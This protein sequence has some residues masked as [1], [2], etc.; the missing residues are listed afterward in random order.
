MIY[1]DL[2]GL[3]LKRLLNDIMIIILFLNNKSQLVEFDNSVTPAE[4]FYSAL[5]YARFKI[6]SILYFS[7][8]LISVL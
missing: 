1:L 2:E 3:K 5:F 6:S 4:A 7:S 8:K